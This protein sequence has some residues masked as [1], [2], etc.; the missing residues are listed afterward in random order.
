[1]HREQALVTPQRS[2]SF[3]DVEAF[4]DERIVHEKPH[5]LG[6]GERDREVCGGAR[7]VAQE[8]VRRELGLR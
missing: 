3:D 6:V 1:M 5:K 2:C 8:A 4:D 7:V